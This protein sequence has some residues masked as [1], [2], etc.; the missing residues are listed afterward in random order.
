M[1]V[2][3]RIPY[4]HPHMALGSTAT[5]GARVYNY[6]AYASLEEEMMS[7]LFVQICGWTAHLPWTVPIVS[8]STFAISLSAVS[9]T[10]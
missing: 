10:Q 1:L 9:C 4:L 2:R 5:E 7:S 8:Q 6:V 3:I